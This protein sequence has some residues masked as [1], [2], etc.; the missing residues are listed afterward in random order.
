MIFEIPPEPLNGIELRGIR[1][2]E[3]GDDVIGPPQCVGFVKSAIVKQENIEACRECLCQPI[4]KNLK[5]V[6]I[7][8]NLRSH[9]EPLQ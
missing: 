6:R 8:Q 5:G 4:D 3:E 1:R 9:S 7:E 2:E